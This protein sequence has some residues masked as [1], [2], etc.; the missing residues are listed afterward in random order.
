MADEDEKF[1]QYLAENGYD[2]SQLGLIAGASDSVATGI[3]DEK[4]ASLEDVKLPT[5]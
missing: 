4:D 1:R 2:T 5:V 3:H